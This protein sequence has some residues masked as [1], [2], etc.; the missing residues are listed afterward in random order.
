MRAIAN[1]F[2]VLLV[3][4][5]LVA[6]ASAPREGGSVSDPCSGPRSMVAGM[7]LGTIAG[8]LIGGRDGAAKGAVVGAMAGAVVCATMSVQSQQTKTA[9]QVD[10]EQLRRRRALPPAPTL[11]AYTPRLIDARVVRG[12]PARVS[13][14]LE[15]ANGSQE[16]V[17]EA[18]EQIIITDP[19]GHEVRTGSK[20]FVAGSA[21]RFENTFEIVLPQQAPVGRYT[22]STVVVLNGKQAATRTVVMQVS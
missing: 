4:M 22:L 21:G 13:S 20:A 16:A 6:C 7:V 12:A 3:S 11:V 8:G 18:V 2:T 17:R 10:E 19:S 15:L 1:R 14:V 9:A 5:S